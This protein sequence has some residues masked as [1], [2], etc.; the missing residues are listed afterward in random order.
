M[1]RASLRCGPTVNLTPRGEV[2]CSGVERAW[3]MRVARRLW[4]EISAGDVKA[5]YSWRKWLDVSD[6]LTWIRKT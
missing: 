1:L 6:G 3:D 4:E 5:L 2:G